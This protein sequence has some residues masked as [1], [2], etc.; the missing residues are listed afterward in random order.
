MALTPGSADGVSND[1]TDVTVVAAPA[2]STQRTVGVITVFNSDTASATVTVKYVNGASGRVVYEEAIP[3]GSTL[4]IDVPII[5]DTTSKS[6][7]I[8]LAGAV[9]TTAL[10]WTASWVDKT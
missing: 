9:T 5:L 2:A 3:V 10:D 8:V 6:V 7:E 1:T 4:E